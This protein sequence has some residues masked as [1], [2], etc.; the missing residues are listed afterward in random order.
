MTKRLRERGG[1]AAKS[2]L[3]ALLELKMPQNKLPNAMQNH[4][5]KIGHIQA[6]ASGKKETFWVLCSIQTFGSIADVLNLKRFSEDTQV[7]EHLLSRGDRVLV[8]EDL[9]AFSVSCLE[10]EVVQKKEGRFVHAKLDP[11]NQIHFKYDAQGGRRIGSDDQFAWK[12]VSHLISTAGGAIAVILDPQIF[13]KCWHPLTEE[14]S[15][16]PLPAMFRSTQGLGYLSLADDMKQNGR[17]FISSNMGYGFLDG[18]ELGNAGGGMVTPSSSGV[19]TPGSTGGPWGAGV[20]S[21]SSQTSYAT[22]SNPPSPA[23]F[24][25]TSSIDMGK[26]DAPRKKKRQPLRQKAAND[27]KKRPSDKKS[28]WR[29]QSNGL[30]QAMQA[31]R[32]KK[33]T[34]DVIVEAPVRSSTPAKQNGNVSD[35]LCSL[36]KKEF[37]TTTQSGKWNE[38]LSALQDLLKDMESVPSLIDRVQENPQLN[39]QTGVVSTAA[40]SPLRDLLNILKDLL[41]D[42]DVRVCACAASVVGRVLRS[43]GRSIG[44][45]LERR[46]LVTLLIGS[47]NHRSKVVLQKV[48]KALIEA[49]GNCIWIC[50]VVSEISV[51]TDAAE[52]KSATARA[53]M[54]DWV[55]QALQIEALHGHP[56]S[57]AYPNLAIVLKRAISER[58]RDPNTRNAAEKGMAA[59]TATVEHFASQHQPQRDPFVSLVERPSGNCGTEKQTAIRLVRAQSAG[60]VKHHQKITSRNVSARG[61]ATPQGKNSNLKR[62]S[63]LSNVLGNSPHAS[64]GGQGS[65]TASIKSVL[66]QLKHDNLKAVQRV[67]AMAKDMLSK[68]HTQQADK[69]VHTDVERQKE[70]TQSQDSPKSGFESKRKIVRRATGGAVGEMND[71]SGTP[72]TK[73]RPPRPVSARDVDDGVGG[74]SSHQGECKHVQ[75]GHAMDKE[76]LENLFFEVKYLLPSRRHIASKNDVDQLCAD[77][78]C[79][80]H[81]L[82]EVEYIA[83]QAGSLKGAVSRWVLPYDD[84][85]STLD[86]AASSRRTA[87]KEETSDGQRFIKFC[88]VSGKERLV[89]EAIALRHLVRVKL[90]DDADL[91]QARQ[92][93]DHVSEFVGSL[94]QYAKS[95]NQD[96][97]AVLKG[98]NV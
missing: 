47:L 25:S 24:T 96:I 46:L 63:S 17:A 9:E 3:K 12:S 76:K 85:T 10:T 1:P 97:S 13:G 19:V 33:A 80:T 92:A 40:I 45:R 95:A 87:G 86:Q 27:E 73:A 77:V 57:N 42:K 89:S 74:Y 48:E 81:F 38:R 52:V 5:R 64:E 71:L 16:R 39:I 90:A 67:E 14:G 54:F 82:D 11:Q 41:K 50:E 53:A 79:A 6:G 20:Y 61:S 51:A 70:N 58:D 2:N 69:R 62:P 68:I 78:R 94:K 4:L 93:I 59:L 18:C 55:A 7:K 36:A 23:S 98:L 65:P 37:F 31:A 49:V 21:P 22:S 84:N 34:T 83:K 88:G 26:S 56:S 66:D 28:K 44:S 15:H 35:I 60:S 91:D 72:N 8:L 43:V 30:R 75:K 32:G 29:E